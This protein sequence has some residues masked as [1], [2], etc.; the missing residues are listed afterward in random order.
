MR[1]NINIKSTKNIYLVQKNDTHDKAQYLV[2]VIADSHKGS[3]Q[4]NYENRQ[5]PT[6]D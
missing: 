3:A 2:L 4:Q 1:R 6:Q 5:L